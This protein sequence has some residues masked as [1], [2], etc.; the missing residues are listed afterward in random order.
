MVGENNSLLKSKYIVIVKIKNYEIFMYFFLI[1][2][3]L[4]FI[5]F[6]FIYNN[7]LFLNNNFLY[8]CYIFIFIKN[9]V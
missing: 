6:F 8:L 5:S 4:V 7:L 2:I 1:V 9:I 3:F